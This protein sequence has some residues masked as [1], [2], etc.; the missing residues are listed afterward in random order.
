M[1]DNK[2]VTHGG[3]TLNLA[4]IKS[5]KL[6]QD[7]SIGKTNILIVEHHKRIEFIKHPGNGRHYKKDIEEVTE[8]VYAD[9]ETAATYRNEWEL[10]WQNYLLEKE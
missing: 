10:I 1:N 9:Y 2:I 7:N 5:F 4:T 8:M 3:L 6:Q